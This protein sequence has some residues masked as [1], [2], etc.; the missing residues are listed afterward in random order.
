MTIEDM[1]MLGCMFAVNRVM[2]RGS[3][4]FKIKVNGKQEIMVPWAEIKEWVEKQYGIE[5]VVTE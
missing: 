1:Y 3:V 5:Q 2:E 4:A